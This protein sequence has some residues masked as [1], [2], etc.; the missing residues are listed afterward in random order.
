MPEGLQITDRHQDPYAWALTQAEQLRRGAAGLKTA[1]REGLREFLEEW[2]EEMLSGARSQLVNLM[3]HMAKVARPRNPAVLGD[4]R[5]ER[6]SARS[7][8]R[9]KRQQNPGFSTASGR[10]CIG[11]SLCFFQKIINHCRALQR[12][13]CGTV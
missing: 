3:A 13:M 8:R 5:R 12:Q 9:R 11:R 2:A 1:D 10:L 6:A 7:I 4:W